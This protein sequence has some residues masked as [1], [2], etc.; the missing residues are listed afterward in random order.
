MSREVDVRQQFAVPAAQVFARIA[1]HE[2]FFARPRFHCQLVEAGTPDRNGDGA[3]REVRVG[4]LRFRER[5]SRFIPNV[6]FD[7]HVEKLSLAGLPL[8]LRHERGW[9]E[10]SDRPSGCEVRWRSRF[11]LRVP[12]LGRLLEARMARDVEKAFTWLLARSARTIESA[13][14]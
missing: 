4:A 12:G 6:G 3:V 1:D 14:A 13:S 9:V 10:I 2:R 8:P 5:I 11:A 7:Y